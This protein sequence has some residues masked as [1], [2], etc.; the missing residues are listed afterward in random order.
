MMAFLSVMVLD[1]LLTI[2]FV[3]SEYR[4]RLLPFGRLDCGDGIVRIRAGRERWQCLLYGV[5]AERQ[6]DEGRHD[7]P[8]RLQQLDLL[9]LGEIRV[10][11][12]GEIFAQVF[13]RGGAGRP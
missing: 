1:F 2:E 10:V 13:L 4:V 11:E 5:R 12:E 7:R 8:Q 3:S 9:R 6:I